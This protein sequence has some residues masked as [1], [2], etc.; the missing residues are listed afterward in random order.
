MLEARAGYSPTGDRASDRDAPSI[1]KQTSIAE[2]AAT[3]NPRSIS[4]GVDRCWLVAI[5]HAGGSYLIS[6]QAVA[7]LACLGLASETVREV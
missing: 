2:E 3:P 7:S 4:S 6:T 1:L 5:P